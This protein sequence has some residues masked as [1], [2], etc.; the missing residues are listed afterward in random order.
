VS[1]PAPDPELARAAERFT[2]LLPAI[3]ECEEPGLRPEGDELDESLGDQAAQ[4]VGP[5]I[6][7]LAGMS[8]CA[9]LLLRL[10][11]PDCELDLDSFY[12]PSGKLHVPEGEEPD[13]RAIAQNVPLIGVLAAGHAHTIAEELVR[14][15][16]RR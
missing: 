2:N 14:L 1:A 10:A 3:V 11:D 5:L 15:R 13:P 7:A 6:A 12:S 16:G 8:V 4:L 9:E